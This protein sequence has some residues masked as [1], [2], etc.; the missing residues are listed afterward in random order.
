MAQQS[1]N[2]NKR[3]RGGKPERNNNRRGADRRFNDRDRQPRAERPESDQEDIAAQTEFVFGHHASV[4]A[5]KGETEI[6]KVWLQTGL[7]DKIRN[8]VMTLAKKRGLVIQDA[9]KAKLDE[10]TDG[11]NHQGVVL[12]I[13][14]YAYATIDDLFAKAAEKDE[15]PFFL[16]LDSIEDPHNLGSILRTADAGANIR[17]KGFIIHNSRELSIL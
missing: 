11:Q 10:L 9:P 3:E 16:V 8:E 17:V 12:S 1:N 14:A 4:E 7:T 2:R 6:N 5:L 13:A 15:A